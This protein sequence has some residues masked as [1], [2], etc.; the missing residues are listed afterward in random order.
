S[1]N[2]TNK[3]PHHTFWWE[4]IDGT[5]VFTHF[6]PVD[7]YN[8]N[9]HASQLAHAEKNFADKGR[10]NTSLVPFGWGDGGGGP[11]REMLAAA[12]RTRDLEGSPTVRVARPTEFFAAAVGGRAVPGVPPRHVHHPG[13]HEARQP[14]QRA[15]A[16][17][18][19]A[20]GHHGGRPGGRGLPRRDA[21]PLLG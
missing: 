20:V 11:T 2:Q 13:A 10:A 17:R 1:W 14:A 12:H 7:T 19:R 5:R 18:G 9:F 15:P 16:A 6:P 3:M 4:G 8:A 21:P